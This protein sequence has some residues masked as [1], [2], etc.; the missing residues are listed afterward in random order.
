MLVVDD[1]ATCRLTMQAMVAALGH[2]CLI[3]VDGGQAWRAL[4]RADIDVVI[5]DRRMP[6]RGGVQLCRRIREELGGRY[7]HVLLATAMDEHSEMLDGMAAGAD[8]YLV[9]PVNMEVL[10]LRLMVAQRVTEVNRKLEHLNAKL[11][12]AAGSDALTGL[13]N[14]RSLDNELVAVTAAVKRYGPRYSIALVDVDHFKAFNDTYGHQAG[15]RALQ[16]IAEVLRSDTRPADT[17]YRYGG[18]EFLGIY[19]YQSAQDVQRAV[20]RIRGRT[21][22]LAIPHAGSPGGVL[23]V[24]AGIAEL[25]PSRPDSVDIIR[26][27]DAALY[28]A[29]RGGRNATLV[30]SAPQTGSQAARHAAARLDRSAS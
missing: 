22:A 4:Q 29:K 1:D 19:P 30:G 13:G 8:D 15:D 24:S 23:T 25:S 11:P 28:E 21:S 9:K 10:R 2:D 3:A 16:A 17:W 18:E 6:G 27:A 20:E 26:R 5:A 12:V 7:V 14:R